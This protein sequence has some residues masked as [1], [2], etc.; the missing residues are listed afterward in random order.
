MKSQDGFYTITLTDVKTDHDEAPQNCCAEKINTL[1]Q[2]S[3]RITHTKYGRICT[4]LLSSTIGLVVYIS[5]HYAG[6]YPFKSSC[7][8]RL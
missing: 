8:K 2:V 6:E 4:L 5:T 3:E 7:I 1:K